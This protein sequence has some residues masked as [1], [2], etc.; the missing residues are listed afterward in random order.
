MTVCAG[1]LTPHANVAV[2]TRTLK[3]MY[4]LESNKFCKDFKMCIG[5]KIGAKVPEY[6]YPQTIL[7]RKSDQFAATRREGWVY[8]ISMLMELN[9]CNA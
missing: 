8:Y 5:T 3:D 6:V 1:K 2:E 9:Q 4:I 7:R